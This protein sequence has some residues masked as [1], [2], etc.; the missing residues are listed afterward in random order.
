MK[1]I[2]CRGTLNVQKLRASDVFIRLH[3]R[4]RG[5]DPEDPYEVEQ[6]WYIAYVS[7]SPYEI[8]LQDVDSDGTEGVGGH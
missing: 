7:L 1:R 4:T 6:F 2:C 8:T 5:S 3:G